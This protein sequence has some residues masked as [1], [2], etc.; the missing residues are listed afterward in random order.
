MS[1]T[2]RKAFTLIEL[3]VVIAIIAI[4]AAILFPVFAQAKEAAKKTQCLSNEKNIGLGLIMYMDDSD[5]M[6]P[7]GQY[8]QTDGHAIFWYEMVY[9]YIKNGDRTSDW[10]NQVGATGMG[11]IFSCPTQ[12]HK[13]VWNYK[14]SYETST[15]GYVPWNP[16]GSIEPAISY[17]VID[18]VADKVAVMEAGSVPPNTSNWPMFAHWET[19]YTLSGVCY[20][21]A[22]DS[23]TCDNSQL[24]TKPGQ[25][26]CD[27]DLG[28]AA[29]GGCAMLPRFRHNL[30]TN[31]A[32][33]DGHAIN[34]KRGT[35]DSGSSLKWFKNI[36]IRSRPAWDT[37]I[38]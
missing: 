36:F 31:T 9:P 38:Y 35:G 18:A 26:D 15:D 12:T 34:F 24:T 4:L 1:H 21:A 27:I 32:M 6:I 10:T 30:A 8:W 16:G 11:G 37:G 29:W 13:D 7:Y 33:W 28:G 2:S 25:G 23:A 22:T 19:A 5:D 3:L 14:L 20:N 17:S